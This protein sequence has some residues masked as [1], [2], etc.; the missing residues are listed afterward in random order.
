[1]DLAEALD[2]AEKSY[3]TPTRITDTEGNSWGS[4]EEIYKNL[5]ESVDKIGQHLNKEFEPIT[6]EWFSDECLDNVKFAG[7]QAFKTG[8]LIALTGHYIDEYGDIIPSFG[9]PISVE[10]H[11][12]RNYFRDEVM[13]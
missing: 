5:K 12:I 10:I 9:P 3:N 1:M 4:A 2:K 8:F 6:V 7:F 13:A 11:R